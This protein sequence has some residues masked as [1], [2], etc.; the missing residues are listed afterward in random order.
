M[1]TILSL[2][3]VSG[4]HA[5]FLLKVHDFEQKHDYLEIAGFACMRLRKARIFSKR[6]HIR[7]QNEPETFRDSMKR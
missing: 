4:V 1:F 3:R 5:L 6:V 7:Y 2:F